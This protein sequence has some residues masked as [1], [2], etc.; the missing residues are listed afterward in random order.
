MT[1][2]TV[3]TW[4]AFE[5][6]QVLHKVEIPQVLQEQ[7]AP[8]DTNLATDVI[9]RLKDRD[10]LNLNEIPVIISE[11]PEESTNSGINR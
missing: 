6:Y 11:K 9:D 7:T 8:L 4:T 5:I 3:L 10:S 2:I 1:L